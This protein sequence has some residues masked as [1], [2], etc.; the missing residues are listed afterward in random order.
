M[1]TRCEL[2]QGGVFAATAGAINGS[3]ETGVDLT[4]KAGQGAR[5]VTAANT[6]IATVV[7]TTGD[8]ITLPKGELGDFF[9]IANYSAVNVLVY[10]PS[11][12]KI[13]GGTA[14]AAFTLTAGKTGKF[15][16]IGSVDFTAFLSA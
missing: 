10:P 6:V 16:Q 1:A 7:G 8:S 2:V 3:I 5:Y 13:Q 4:G 9:E 12:G 14:D 11:G 15:R